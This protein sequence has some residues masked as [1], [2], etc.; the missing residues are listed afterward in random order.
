[1]IKDKIA[2]PV[3]AEKVET[4]KHKIVVEPEA[5]EAIIKAVGESTTPSR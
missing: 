5:K 3:K 4:F 2:K 1:M